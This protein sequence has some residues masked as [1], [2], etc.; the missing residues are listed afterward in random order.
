MERFLVS[1]LQKCRK[2]VIYKIDKIEEKAKPCSTLI[3]VL[4][5]R[6]MK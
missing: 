5:N 1:F 2:K 6:D 4:K 3:F